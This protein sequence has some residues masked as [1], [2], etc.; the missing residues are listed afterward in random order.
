MSC[1]MSLLEMES[2]TYLL[3]SSGVMSPVLS[4][5]DHGGGISRARATRRVYC[6][7]NKIDWN[8]TEQDG[9]GH[10]GRGG[11]EHVGAKLKG[12]AK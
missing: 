10:H 12:R 1:A 8:E 4:T 3:T 2:P 9:A 5:R 11:T 6:F 7:Q